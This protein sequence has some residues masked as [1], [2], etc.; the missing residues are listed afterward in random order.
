MNVDLLD[1][2]EYI[3]LTH[4]E[5]FLAFELDFST[6]ILA[7]EHGVALFEYHLLVFGAIT[8]CDDSSLKR[9]FLCGVGDDDATDFLFCRCRKYEHS[10]C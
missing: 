10:V 2:S 7:I 9:F 3:A 4:D 8:G 1:D 6:G 5:V